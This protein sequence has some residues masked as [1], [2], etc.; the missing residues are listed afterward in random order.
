MKQA[1]VVRDDLLWAGYLLL[2]GVLFGLLYQW[3]LVKIAWR[4]EL[5]AFLD[6][7]HEQRRATEF[8][9]IPTV[10]LDKALELW[11]QGETLFIDVRS[12][13]DFA[14]LHVPRAINVP[15]EKL[16]D[17]QELEKAGILG[18][19][20]DRQ[21][22]VYCNTLRCNSSLK[23]AKRLQSLGFTRVLAFLGGFQA[24]DEAGYDV[25]SKR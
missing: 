3:P 15:E 18:L 4:G 21:I 7:M 19:P 23:A 6:K 17:Q 5:N 14:D 22:L 24:W 9:G 8:K 1:R 12:A 16:A 11:Q 25:D 13:D 20:R 2:L 10:K